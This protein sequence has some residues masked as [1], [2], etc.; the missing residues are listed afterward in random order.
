MKDRASEADEATHSYLPN[1]SEVTVVVAEL[2]TEV[3]ADD[4][5]VVPAEVDAD[6]VAEEIA[7]D[8]AVV[9]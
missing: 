9:D 8:D 5:T 1:K 7:V 3:E 4:E 2:V 6:V